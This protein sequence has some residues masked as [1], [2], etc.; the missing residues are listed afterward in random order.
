M[1]SER[2]PR[3]VRPGKKYLA[4]V[5]ALATA[6]QIR[7][8]IRSYGRQ[9]KL[10]LN[11]SSSSC[12]STTTK[13]AQRTHQLENILS[14]HL[15]NRTTQ[16]IITRTLIN[17]AACTSD[18]TACKESAGLIDYLISNFSIHVAG[19]CGP[20]HNEPLQLFYTSCRAYHARRSSENH[21]HG[22]LRLVPSSRA[23]DGVAVVQDH[24]VVTTWR[25]PDTT[26]AYE[27]FF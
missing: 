23:K 5:V 3:M 20:N 8:A 25:I 15:S 17:M 27:V 6:L 21:T 9:H 16:H 24:D 22:L 26:T 10:N 14:Y 12:V 1:P 19:A 7:K 13:L 2:G 18:K 4:S 11:R